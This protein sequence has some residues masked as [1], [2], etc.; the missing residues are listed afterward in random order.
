M[1]ARRWAAAIISLLLL[2]SM[3]QS[4]S[5]AEIASKE[6]ERRA[7]LKGKP[8]VVVTNAELGMVKPDE[9]LVQVSARP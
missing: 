4:Q 8:A 2:N 5:L 6:R 3:L 1:P 9:I 7:A